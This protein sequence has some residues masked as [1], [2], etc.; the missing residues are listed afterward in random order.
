MDEATLRRLAVE[1]AG[2][3]PPDPQDARTVLRLVGQLVD[4]FLFPEQP[5]RCN[6]VLLKADG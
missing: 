1:I 2:N 4:T 6:I 5:E 3:L